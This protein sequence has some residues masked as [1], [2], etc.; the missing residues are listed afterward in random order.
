MGLVK[1]EEI[2]QYANEKKLI[3]DKEAL[4]FLEGKT[5][6]KELLEKSVKRGEFVVKKEGLEKK[7]VEVQGKSV[8]G[9]AVECEAKYRVLEEFDLKESRSRGKIEDFLE[10]FQ[11]KFYTLE[12]IIKSH[13]SFNPKPIKHLRVINKNEEIELVGMVGRK[14][15]TKNNHTAFELEDLE[16]KCIMLIL[17]DDKNLE[18]EKELILLDNVIGVKAAK[19]SDE[20]VI[21]KEIIWPDLKLGTPKYGER[22]LSVAGLSDLH[23]GSKLHLERVVGEFIKWING[24]GLNGKEREEVGKIKYLIVSGDNVEGVGIYPSQYNELSIKNIFEQYE[25]FSDLMLQVPEHIEIFIIPGQHDAVRWADPQPAIGKEFVPELHKA[26]NIHLLSSPSWIEIEGL[27]TLMYHGPS[28]HDLF[29]QVSFLSAS[30][31]EEGMVELL[32]KRDLMCSYGFGRPYVPE[33]K[34]FMLLREEPDLVFIGD[35]HRIGYAHYR[36]TTII[37]NSTFQT[38]T[39]YQKELGHVP[40]PGIIPMVNLK[41]RAIKEKH[42]YKGE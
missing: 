6:W 16:K 19:I 13:P 32:K 31:P 25:V 5:D 2:L 29:S 1:A 15:V 14:W 17:K 10:Y 36:G 28:L 21:A 7:P 39:D 18:R 27:K 12:K 30:K 40:T 4:E 9:N 38:E 3:V 20:L 37:N 34:D 33:K 23:I 26:K 11:N 24:K 22:D 8:K 41:T 35:H 42:F